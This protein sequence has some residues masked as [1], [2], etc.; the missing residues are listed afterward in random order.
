[1]DYCSH[2]E[3]RFQILSDDCLPAGYASGRSLYIA[4]PRYHRPGYAVPK[5][6]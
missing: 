5:P 2:V 3:Q 1:M 4:S 6:I